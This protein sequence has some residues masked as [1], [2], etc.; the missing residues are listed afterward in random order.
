M[1]PFPFNAVHYPDKFNLNGCYNY[2]M[3]HA[4]GADLFHFANADVCFHPG[5]DIALRRHWQTMD[6]EDVR[7]TKLIASHSYPP[8]GES[9]RTRRSY[10]NQPGR[11][12]FESEDPL[13]QCFSMQPGFTFDER[14]D[15]WNTDCDLWLHCKTSGKRMLVSRESRVDHFND[16]SVI[17]SVKPDILTKDKSN[18][19][20]RHK[21]GNLYKI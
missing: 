11:G 15:G 16:S 6:P 9:E 13:L 19:L 5:W 20:M 1:D 17:N 3:A 2:G 4:H 14:F 10:L 8:E 21:W 18:E 7:R 12:T